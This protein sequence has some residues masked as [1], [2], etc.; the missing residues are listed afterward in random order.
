MPIPVVCP[1]CKSR[2]T[3]SDQ[4]AGRTGPC[5]KCK[6]TIKVPTP[7]AKAVVIH[8]PEAPVASSSGTGKAPTAPIKRRNKPVS[9][10]SFAA[11]AVGAVLFMGI[12]TLLPVVYPPQAA[13]DESIAR[14]SIPT[15]LLLGGGF[16]AALPAVLLGYAAVR[17]RELE[18]YQGRPLAVRVLTCALVYATLW[19][20]RGAIPWLNPAWQMTDMYEWFMLGPLFVAAGA[21]AALATLDLE[22]GGAAVH[23]SFYVLFTSLLRW[24]AGLPPL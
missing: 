10:G 19:A 14:T 3:V 11:A 1:S 20:I 12:A 5:P 17:N 16:A 21:L 4:F 15:W 7:A 23:F 24:L 22:P 18:P 2:F 6:Q 13:G 8:E 9:L